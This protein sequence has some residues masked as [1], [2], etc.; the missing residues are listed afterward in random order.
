MCDNICKGVFKQCKWMLIT[1]MNS[2]SKKQSAITKKDCWLSFL[3]FMALWYHLVPGDNKDT[4]CLVS[5]RWNRCHLTNPRMHQQVVGMQGTLQNHPN[6]LHHQQQLLWHQGQW[7]GTWNKNI[8]SLASV[9]ADIIVS[10]PSRDNFVPFKVKSH[11]AIQTTW[12]AAHCNS[13]Q[14]EV[15]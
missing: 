2:H 4:T 14:I 6:C 3:K 11:N 9:P 8:T 7:N 15:I 1:G 13:V 5:C 10:I 12:A